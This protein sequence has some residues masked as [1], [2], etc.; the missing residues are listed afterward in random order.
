MP[1]HNRPYGTATLLTS[2]KLNSMCNAENSALPIGATH[3]NQLRSKYITIYWFCQVRK[4]I[5]G[6]LDWIAEKQ[7][8]RSYLLLNGQAVR[9]ARSC[10]LKIEYPSAGS[11]TGSADSVPW[12]ELAHR[13]IAAQRQPD[14][15][16]LKWAQE[17]A[18]RLGVFWPNKWNDFYI[19]TVCQRELF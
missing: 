11:Y 17:M 7:K 15:T 16:R 14:N 4:S 2:Y 1:V 18:R 19:G 6:I 9:S 13:R 10:T 8:G 12:D 5:Y 3:K